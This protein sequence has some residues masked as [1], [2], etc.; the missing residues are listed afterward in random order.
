MINS[1]DIYKIVPLTLVLAK[2][3]FYYLDSPKSD[4]FNIYY[5]FYIK[6]NPKNNYLF[7]YNY[8]FYFI[9]IKI[10]KG[11]ISKWFIYLIFK[12]YKTN[13]IYYNIKYYSK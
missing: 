4:N 6:Y 13:I 5:V 10:F 2:V 11:L 1:G 12:L 7:Y 3:F 9:I 8:L